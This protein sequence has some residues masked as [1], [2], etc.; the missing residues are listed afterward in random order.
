MKPNITK[1]GFLG[2][3][4]GVN[5]QVPYEKAKAIIIP[6]GMEAHVTYGTGTK[7]GPKAILTASHELNENDEQTFYAVHKCGLS[8]LK[9][10]LV[11][12]DS[13]KA[14]GLLDSLVSRVL[15]DGKFPLVLGGEHTVTAGALKAI[16][17]NYSNLSVL[18][19]DAHAD[20]R[21]QYRGSVY[22]HASALRMVMENCPIEKLVQVGIRT[23]SEIDDELGFMQREKQKIKTFWG[24]QNP[25]SEEVAKLLPTENVYITFDVDAF[26]SSLMPSTGTPEPGGLLWWPTLKILKEVFKQKNVVGADVVELSPIKGLHGP[27]YLVARLVYKML[28][29]KFF[30]TTTKAL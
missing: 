28:G 8:T 19:F 23:V 27:N 3:D 11:P 20:L 4:Q 26:D 10:P 30:D 5:F 15:K 21:K 14:L 16:C 1:N 22:S 17:R 7:K 29:Y 12:K 24:W 18:H 9:E 2:I 6:F 25:K 13:A